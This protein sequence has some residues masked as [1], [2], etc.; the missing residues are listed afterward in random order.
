MGSNEDLDFEILF[1]EALIKERPDYVD[2][3]VALGDV[4]TKRGRYKEGLRVDLRLR[5]LRP[6]DPVVHYNLA[7]SYS[8]LKAA[9][10]CLDALE[11]ALKLG[12]QDFNFIEK[13]SDLD[14]IRKD[15]RYKKILSKYKAS[16]H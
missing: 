15:P 12:Y 5:Q 13:D 1:F 16:T 7:C 11:R 8:L 4:Y 14:F 2:A 9:N 3:L 6:N 10:D